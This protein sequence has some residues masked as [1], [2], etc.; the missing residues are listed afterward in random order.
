M[1]TCMYA[2]TDE[3]CTVVDTYFFFLTSNHTALRLMELLF[4]ILQ[5]DY[6]QFN[7]FKRHVNVVLKDLV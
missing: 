1:R 3:I 2:C 4:K 5:L 6:M 7:V